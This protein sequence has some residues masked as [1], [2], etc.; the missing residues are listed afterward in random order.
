MIKLLK[1]RL[2]A[3][4]L[5][6]TFFAAAP[7][8]AQSPAPEQTLKVATRVIAPF[9]VQEGNGLTG[10][11]VDLWRALAR[12]LGIKFEFTVKNTV[13][14]LL[15]EVGEKRADL[16]IAAISITAERE[17]RFDFSQP[18]FDA[19]LQILV[20]S[21]RSGGGALS[22]FLQMLKSPALLE[23]LGILLVLTLLP[24]PIIMMIERHEGGVAHAKTGLG[25]FFNSIWW[26][27]GTIG[28]QAPLMPTSPLGK[29]I[30]VIWMFVS[31]VFI[32]FFKIGRAH[33]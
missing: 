1:A 26:S 4:F 7:A 33:V 5:V 2:A 19:G 11:S 18:M 23:M 17:K 9:V 3:T 8:P 12:D 20:S 27:S 28:A 30:A 29:L 24:I 25:S 6:L 21:D 15:A 14:E 22:G 32:S 16:A 13:P 31:V 10:F